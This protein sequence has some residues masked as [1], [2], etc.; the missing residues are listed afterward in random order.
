M[1]KR[2]WFDRDALRRSLVQ[3][4][5]AW[6]VA[7][8]AVPTRVWRR[9]AFSLTKLL[10]FSSCWMSPLLFYACLLLLPCMELAFL[11]WSGFC[12]LG[13]WVQEGQSFLGGD[14]FAFLLVRVKWRDPDHS[15]PSSFLLFSSLV[16][17]PTGLSVLSFDGSREW[18]E[19][20]LFD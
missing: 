20:S 6:L 18:G 2:N 8:I 7:T 1:D 14:Q 11:L 10:S 19:G 9:W 17:H 4:W 3:T 15:I 16:S 13:K 5:L 12:S